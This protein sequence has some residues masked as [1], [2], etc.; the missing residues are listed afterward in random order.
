MIAWL[1]DV[2]SW[3]QPHGRN[4]CRLR[5]VSPWLKPRAIFDKAYERK[6]IRKE[7]IACGF[8]HRTRSISTTIVYFVGLNPILFPWFKSR[9]IFEK[10]TQRKHSLRFQPHGHK[11]F[12]QRLCILLD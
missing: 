5:N 10:H 1:N 2:F 6:S 8:N 4:E 7:N 9:F 3:L 11:E 12:P